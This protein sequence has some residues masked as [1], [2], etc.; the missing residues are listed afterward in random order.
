MCDSVFCYI[1]QTVCYLA[2]K[3]NR[4]RV[5]KGTVHPKSQSLSTHP[6]VDVKFLMAEFSILGKLFLEFDHSC[7]SESD[8]KD[9]SKKKKKNFVKKRISK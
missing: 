3:K 7:K 4:T 9:L 1:D 5:L 2:K 6:H 8:E